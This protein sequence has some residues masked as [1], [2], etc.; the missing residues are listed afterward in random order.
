MPPILEGR[1]NW[2]QLFS[3][4][5]A[6]SDLAGLTTRAERDGDRFDHQ[7]PE[8]VEQHGDAGRLRHAARGTDFSVPKHNGISWFAFPLDQPGVTIRPLREMTGDAV[9]NEVFFDDAVCD[10]ADLIGGEGNGW[11]VTQTTLLL[12]TNR[13]RRGW[14]ARRLPRTRVRRAA[15]SDGAPATR[16]PTRCR[17]A[18]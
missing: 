6:G 12:R 10:A 8:G 7:R 1:V 5:G 11:A 18:T 3:E 15:C 17:A 16:P 4:P 13:H 14:L 9:F 2:C